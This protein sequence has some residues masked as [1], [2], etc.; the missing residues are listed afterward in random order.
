MS[1][2]TQAQAKS[3]L[4]FTPAKTL[5]LSSKLSADISGVEGRETSWRYEKRNSEIKVVEPSENLKSLTTN[6]A[7]EV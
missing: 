5:R 7:A 3:G 2:E 6:Q 1:S 4:Y